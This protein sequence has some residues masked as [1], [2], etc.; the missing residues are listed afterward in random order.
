MERSLLLLSDDDWERFDALY[1]ANGQP[2]VAFDAYGKMVIND[3]YLAA[4]DARARANA[5]L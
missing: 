3:P 1:G 4:L 2:L 5:G